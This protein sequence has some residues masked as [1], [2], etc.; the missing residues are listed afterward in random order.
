VEDGKQCHPVCKL[1]LNGDPLAVTITFEL[2][3]KKSYGGG[4]QGDGAT[5]YNVLAVLPDI[6]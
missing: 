2:D 5:T 1:F 6:K 4:C 3:I